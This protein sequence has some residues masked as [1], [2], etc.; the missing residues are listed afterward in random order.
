MR[1]R[2]LLLLSAVMACGCAGLQ[3]YNYNR[4]QR[5]R[6]DIAWREC[7]GGMHSGMSKDFRDG[8]KQGYVDL[9]RG[10]CDELPAVPPHKYWSAAYQSEEGRCCIEQWY[11]GWRSGADAA[12]ASGNP[13]WHRITPSPAAPSPAEN[14][15]LTQTAQSSPMGNAAAQL[16]QRPQLNAVPQASPSFKQ[17]PPLPEEVEVAPPS[18]PTEDPELQSPLSI[19]PVN[20]ETGF[21]VDDNYAVPADS[22]EASP[23]GE[24]VENN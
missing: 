23:I 24:G 11:A 16:A 15:V 12:K 19:R 17:A 4:T 14:A 7:Y 10:M 18:E 6:A 20:G 5:Q 2:Y 9:S 3:D 1:A 13:E 21:T 22:E 8:W